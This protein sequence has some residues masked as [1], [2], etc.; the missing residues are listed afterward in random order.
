MD[1]VIIDAML[2]GLDRAWDNGT[3]S[4]AQYNRGRDY[5][6]GMVTA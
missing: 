6:A 5:L 1:K 3:L 4:D 2:S